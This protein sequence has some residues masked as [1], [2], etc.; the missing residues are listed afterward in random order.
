MDAR[1]SAAVSYQY[2]TRIA[3]THCKFSAMIEIRS[4]VHNV[5]KP[6]DCKARVNPQ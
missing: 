6:N 5:T 2:S 4:R 1:V 3:Q